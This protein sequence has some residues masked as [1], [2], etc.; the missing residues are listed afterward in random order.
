MGLVKSCVLSLQWFAS[1]I[2][3]EGGASTQPP[4]IPCDGRFHHALLTEGCDFPGPSSQPPCPSW[5][6]GLG[7]LAGAAEHLPDVCF[8]SCHRASAQSRTGIFIL[9]ASP[10]GLPQ[11]LQHMGEPAWR[12]GAQNQARACPRGCGWGPGVPELSSPGPACLGGTRCP[13]ASVLVSPVFLEGLWQPRPSPCTL[14]SFLVSDQPVCPLL[15]EGETS[16]EVEHSGTHS[17]LGQVALVP[18]LGPGP[19]GLPR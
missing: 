5:P 16:S 15:A 13:G 11:P 10:T 4:L 9:V 19:P 6:R 8:P 2:G 18:A 3:V 7:G 1:F 17:M 14:P 12:G